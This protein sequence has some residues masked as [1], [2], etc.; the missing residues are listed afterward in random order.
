VFE[1]LAVATTA[2]PVVTFS[3][4]PALV[5]QLVLSTFMPLLVGLVTT[6]V[7]SGATKAWLLAAFTLVTSVLT[8]IGDAI[9]TGTPFDI[10]LA[11]LLLIPAFV[12]SV[13]TYYGLWKPTGIAVKA[14]DVGA[15]K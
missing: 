10:G 9:A 4:D 2:A 8:G 11:L 5:I 14:Q 7:T 3:V 1:L 15:N 13:S 12:V 6:R